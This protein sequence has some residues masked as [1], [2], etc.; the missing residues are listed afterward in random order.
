M[1][2]IKVTINGKKYDESILIKLKTI[3]VKSL[4]Y[5]EETRGSGTRG[6]RMI[7]PQRG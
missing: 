6:H 4:L 7:T 3:L 1:V 2:T 5:E